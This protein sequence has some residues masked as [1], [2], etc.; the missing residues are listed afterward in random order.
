LLIERNGVACCA[1]VAAVAFDTLS[2][3]NPQR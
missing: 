2:P 1:A 3:P